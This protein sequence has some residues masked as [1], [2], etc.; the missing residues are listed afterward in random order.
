MYR[1]SIITVNYND[2]EGLR[3][4]LAS[5]A[6]QTY[7][8]IEHIIIDGGST[9]GSVDVIREYAES[10]ATNQH[11]QWIS[12]V[13]GGIYDAMNKGIAKSTGDYLL[14]LNGGD[15]LVSKTALADAYPHLI[16]DD[17]IIGRTSFSYKGT[18]RGTSPLLTE[19]DLSM[20]RM[21]LKGINHQS[22]FIKRSLLVENPYDVNVRINA[23]WL[24]FV[25]E[26]VMKNASVKFVDLFFVDFDCSGLSSN[27]SAVIK[28]REEVIKK[29]LPPR[30]AKDYIQILPHYYEVVR[31]QW[32]LKHPICYKIYR[33]FTTLCRKILGE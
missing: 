3:K 25:Q 32:L 15:A 7:Q 11:V 5:V 28:E 2:V 33:G 31:V 9:D 14:F 18:Q 6:S 24:F 16:N 22:A 19:Q 17:F 27:T 1:I 13:D 29:I 8:E 26:I 23:D 20:Y 21:Y 12:E 10:I 30:I 4:T